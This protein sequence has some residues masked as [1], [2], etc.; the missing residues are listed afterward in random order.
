[1]NTPLTI[2]RHDLDPR[3][4]T[5]RG[6][7]KSASIIVTNSTLQAS[8]HGYHGILLWSV[9]LSSFCKGHSCRRFKLLMPEELICNWYVEF[10]TPWCRSFSS[11]LWILGSV[12]NHLNFPHNKRFRYLH[13]RKLTWIH[14]MHQKNGLE[15]GNSLKTLNMATVCNMYVRFL[16]CF[17]SFTIGVTPEGPRARSNSVHPLPPALP[18]QHLWPCHPW[19]PLPMAP[20]T[21]GRG[22]NDMCIKASSMEFGKMHQAAIFVESCSSS[23]LLQIACGHSR[24]SSDNNN[25]Q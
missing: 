2:K 20:S 18:Q 9:H 7:R 19:R 12:T 24:S 23:F 5:W 25:K 14:K 17:H 22:G 11:S 21:E 13:P 15:K 1:M 10:C 4:L 3:Y 8:H 6:G 16:G